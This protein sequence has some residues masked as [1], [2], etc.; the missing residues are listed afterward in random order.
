VDK[1]AVFFGIYN[2]SDISAV[3]SHKGPKI[4][5]FAGT[6]STYEK[7]LDL[8]KPSI[9]DKTIVIA[10]SKWVEDD[11]DK[12][13]IKYE[14]LSIFI[15]NTWKWAVA[16][17]GKSIYW[18]GGQN[19]R[20]GKQYVSAV[21]SAFPNVKIIITDSSSFP[22]EKMSEVYAKC[23]C[24]VRM[25]EHD[26]LSQ[27]VAEAALMGRM[28][29][30]NGNGPFALHYNDINDVI[31]HIK[32]LQ[33][34]HNEKLVAK[35]ARGFFFENEAK[36][37]NIVLNLCG[38]EKVDSSGIFVE[39]EER[40]PSFFR[41]QRKKDIEKIGGLGTDNFERPWFSQKM[42]ELGKKQLITTKSSGWV[43]KEFKGTGN[44]G[45]PKGIEY[46]T[47]DKKYD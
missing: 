3:L 4:I 14:R 47:H 18:Y 20:Y 43:V 11:L 31:G 40:C 38:V 33:E 42:R 25:T 29:I 30:W 9:D 13:G 44:K 8:I 17:L 23:F 39:D 34:G 28:S 5:W 21:Q 32:R 6:D 37:A 36:W 10:E 27:S 19:S 46:H 41:I 16:P 45:Y 2:L 12:A 22:H 15:D 1:P 26:G 7:N 35:R 24:T